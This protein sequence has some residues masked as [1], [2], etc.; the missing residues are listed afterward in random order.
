MAERQR[1]PKASNVNRLAQVKRLPCI[2]CVTG[3]VTWNQ[4]GPSEV[5]HL[6]LG[7]KA[8]QKRRGDKYTIPLGVWH[9]RGDPRSGWT[10]TEMADV[11][12]PSL[13]RQSKAFRLR[14]GCDEYLLD[15]TNA[16]LRKT[17]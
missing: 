9:H 7:G 12:G 1:K 13:A 15:R 8:G 17:T 2:A 11:Y 5:H 3:G 4:C 6:N 16:M 14:F 10:A